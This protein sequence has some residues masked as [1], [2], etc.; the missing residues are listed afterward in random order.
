MGAGLGGGP[1]WE[2]PSWG[3]GEGSWR[4]PRGGILGRV[5]GKVGPRGGA[6]GRGRSSNPGRRAGVGAGGGGNEE[7]GWGGD[8]GFLDWGGEGTQLRASWGRRGFLERRR[9][10]WRRTWEGR[11]GPGAWGGRGVIPGEV[12]GRA[13][14]KG[15]GR[16]RQGPGGVPGAGG[17][18]RLGGPSW[19]VGGGKGGGWGCKGRR[20]NPGNE[21][22]RSGPGGPWEGILR[23]FLGVG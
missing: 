18:G 13:W 17:C 22:G 3:L 7:G 15:G 11:G 8:E 21:D 23:W 16:E 6:P 2:G 12:P 14:G 10:A 20:G 1:D 19:S 5:P 4:G 9:G